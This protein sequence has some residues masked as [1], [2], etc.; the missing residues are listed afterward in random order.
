MTGTC[1]KIARIFI[2]LF[3]L[4][5]AA[6]A[7]V[8]VAFAEDAELLKM[9]PGQWTFNDVFETEQEMQEADLVLTLGQ[10]GEMSLHFSINGGERE[11]SYGGTWSSE[12]ITEASDETGTN[13]RLTL[14]FTSTDNPLHAG[15]EYSVECVYYIY[16]E[17]WVENDTHITALI[18]EMPSCSGISPFE[19]LLGYDAI[20]LD[21]KEGPN[22]RVVN[23]KDYVSLRQKPSTTSVRLAK[24]PLGALVLAYPEAGER[25]GFI[26]CTYHGEDGYILAE[27]LEPVE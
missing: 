7:C 12:L 2:L 3:T 11:Y 17:G 21:R 15:S 8:T 20:A 22:M 18:L 6:Q 16:A 5:F 13:D 9:L 1:R 25:N 4:T 23:C 27:Y 24:V 19:E 10:E 26:S 14:N